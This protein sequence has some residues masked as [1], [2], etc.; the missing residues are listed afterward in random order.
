MT[1]EIIF[2]THLALEDLTT[3]TG[4]HFKK[5]YQKNLTKSNKKR[6]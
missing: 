4:I 6:F 1:L 2:H 3:Q 5:I